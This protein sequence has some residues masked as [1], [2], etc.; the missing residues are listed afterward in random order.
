MGPRLVSRGGDTFEEVGPAGELLQWGRGWLAA[1]APTG[2]VDPYRRDASMGPRLV[3]RGGADTS[4]ER[5]AI[6]LA[7]MGPRLVSRG[8]AAMVGMEGGLKFGFN[9]AAAG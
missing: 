2:S 4:D 9:G 7:S 8:G 5:N 3:S 6:D 1:E